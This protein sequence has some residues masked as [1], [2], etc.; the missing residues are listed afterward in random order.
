MKNQTNIMNTIQYDKMQHTIL[1]YAQKLMNSQL[2]LHME[3]NK[4]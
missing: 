4:E 2:N 3:P 1:T